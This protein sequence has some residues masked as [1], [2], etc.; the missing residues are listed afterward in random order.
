MLDLGVIGKRFHVTAT[1]H[2]G[3]RTDRRPLAGVPGWCYGER[4]AKKA[5][6]LSAPGGYFKSRPGAPD[7]DLVMNCG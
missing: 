4:D 3:S 5:G 2:P 1:R 7:D 6:I